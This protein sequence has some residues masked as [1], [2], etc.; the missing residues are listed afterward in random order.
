MAGYQE[1]LRDLAVSETGFLFDP[2][3]GATY[4]TNATGR[5]ILQALRDGLTRTQTLEQL[6]GEFEVGD[7]D[8]DLD[9][10]LDEFILMLRENG[11]L[12]SDFA[13]EP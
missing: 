1:R 3:S 9:R 7:P 5:V 2:F 10:D 11:I 6:R 4:N 13:L 12:P 8:Y